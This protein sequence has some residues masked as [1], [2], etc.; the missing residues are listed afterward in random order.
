[1]RPLVIA[2][3]LVAAAGAA[4]PASATT[5]V[6]PCA[7]RDAH[8]M[9]RDAGQGFNG[10]VV[11]IRKD[12]LV[13]EAESR[14]DPGTIG[15]GERVTVFG[16]N[17][18]AI[19][20]GRIGIA[21]RRDGARWRATRCDVIPAARMANALSGREPCP[22]PVVRIA[23]LSAV[24]RLAQLDLRFRGDVTGVRIA[25]GT[26]VVR[27]SLA[28]GVASLVERHRFTTT[29]RRRVDVRVEGGFGPGCGAARRRTATARRTIGV[30]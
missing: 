14:Y 13:I 6:G 4:P 26:A 9:L 22:A 15:F 24:G 17:L 8:A 28:P 27:R 7:P 5:A 19:P 30:G 11:E 12:R 23:K 2:L 10:G 16:P 3:A 29:G 1:M 18:P 20:R 21:V 25:W